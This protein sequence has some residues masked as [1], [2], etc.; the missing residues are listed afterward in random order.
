[1]KPSTSL[2]TRAKVG[3]VNPSP[4]VRQAGN[5]RGLLRI[6]EVCR[7]N[8]LRSCSHVKDRCR[9][10]GMM[11]WREKP[12]DLAIELLFDKLNCSL[13]NDKTPAAGPA[14]VSNNP[15]HQSVSAWLLVPSLFDT[16]H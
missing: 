4:L 7:R 2:G 12:W 6:H 8:I 14:E 3:M 1:M 11:P 9:C 10:R 5:I 16:P 13:T 15:C